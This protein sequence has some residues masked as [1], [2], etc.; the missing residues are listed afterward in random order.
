M[1]PSSADEIGSSFIWPEEDLELLKG[2]LVHNMSRLWVQTGFRYL[3]KI[4]EVET[5]HPVLF[6]LK[7]FGDGSQ[8]SSLQDRRGVPEHNGEAQLE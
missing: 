8:V 3:L 6:V 7:A 2:S 5:K 1:L 4:S